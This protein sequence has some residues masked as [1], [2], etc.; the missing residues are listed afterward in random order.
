MGGGPMDVTYKYEVGDKVKDRASGKTGVV[1]FRRIGSW[2]GNLLYTVLFH[3]WLFG[4]TS[5]DL[6][7]EEIKKA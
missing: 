4:D 3:S 6:Y 2:T 1:T 7:E 5:E